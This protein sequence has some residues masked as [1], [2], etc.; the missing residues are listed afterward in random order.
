M[1]LGLLYSRRS[2]CECGRGVIKIG[3]HAIDLQGYTKR[4]AGQ[5]LI[6]KTSAKHA[7]ALR[8]CDLKV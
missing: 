8:D 2:I 3:K 5:R 4:E 7:Y 6:T 1:V